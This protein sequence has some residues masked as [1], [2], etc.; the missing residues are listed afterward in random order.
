MGNGQ[1]EI[2]DGRLDIG[3]GRLEIG[4]WR[5]D[6][7]NRLLAMGNGRLVIGYRIWKGKW[8]E[9]WIK[10]AYV[11]KKYYFCNDLQNY[12]ATI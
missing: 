8:D 12:P 6:I 2:G 4:Y 3:D 5:W 10:F 11:Q 1:W 9:M 7:G